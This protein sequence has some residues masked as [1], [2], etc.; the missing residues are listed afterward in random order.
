MASIDQYATSLRRQLQNYM[1]G[2]ADIDG[3]VRQIVES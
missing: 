3:N 1:R 2:Q